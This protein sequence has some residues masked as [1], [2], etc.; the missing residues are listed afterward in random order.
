MYAS[1][2]RHIKTKFYKYKWKELKAATNRIKKMSIKY[3]KI[4][5]TKR[6]L[7]LYGAKNA[8]TLIFVCSEQITRN[9]FFPYSF[10]K[11]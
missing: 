5:T 11:L 9:N 3:Y 1:C 10:L 8:S 4:E 7:F 6:H 2:F